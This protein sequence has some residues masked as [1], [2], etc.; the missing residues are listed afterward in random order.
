MHRKEGV[1]VFRS[2]A[3]LKASVVGETIRRVR[4]E[5]NKQ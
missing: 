4:K 1:W 3:P 5:R 2:G